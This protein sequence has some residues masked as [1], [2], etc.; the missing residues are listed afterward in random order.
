MTIKKDFRNRL[1][2]N[3][4]CERGEILLKEFARPFSEEDLDKY[5]SKNGVSV[6]E[7]LGYVDMNENLP[8]FTPNLANTPM[9]SFSRRG[10]TFYSSG[11]PYL[12]F[13]TDVNRWSEDGS[14]QISISN[15]M[16]YLIPGGRSG[17]M[18]Y[19]KP[20]A[21]YHYPS[22]KVFFALTDPEEKRRKIYNRDNQKI[23]D[24][25]KLLN[26]ISLFL[27]EFCLEDDNQDFFHRD[28]S[29][30][31]I[32]ELGRR[33]VT[34]KEYE[35]TLM[36]M[37][38]DEI[39]DGNE[40]I[41]NFLKNLNYE[42]AKGGKSEMDFF[43]MLLERNYK[44]NSPIFKERQ[45]NRKIV[46]VFEKYKRALE[47][48]DNRNKS[49]AIIQMMMIDEGLVNEINKIEDILKLHYEKYSSKSIYIHLDDYAGDAGSS[50]SNIRYGIRSP[51]FGFSF[52]NVK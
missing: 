42:E 22:Q 51:F 5:K 10:V 6:A 2:N 45:I 37:S 23:K 8:S 39:C 14:E 32:N 33:V 13:T 52:Y 29:S 3:I 30:E 34:L 19:I 1:I 28:T 15:P 4:L 46:A 40:N 49:I 16:R 41:K 20:I 25:Q 47:E 27:K 50:M 36:D 24:K 48:Y 11:L 31:L 18:N 12:S 21:I 38:L 17:V 43:N 7:Q 26:N 35:E 9:T 44:H